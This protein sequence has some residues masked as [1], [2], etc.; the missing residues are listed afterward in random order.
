MIKEQKKKVMCI[1]VRDLEKDFNCPG[2][3]FL[4]IG[5]TLYSCPELVD[6]IRCNCIFTP[7]DPEC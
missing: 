5:S 3:L 6:N 2:V 7:I 4:R 1:D